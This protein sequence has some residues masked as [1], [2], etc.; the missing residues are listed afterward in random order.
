MKGSREFSPQTADDFPEPAFQVR[1][2]KYS[3]ESCDMLEIAFAPAASSQYRHS[4]RSVVNG[5]SF[6]EQLTQG[7][8]GLLRGTESE[9]LSVCQKNRV[10]GISRRLR[11]HLAALGDKLR[12]NRL[13][14]KHSMPSGGLFTSVR[15]PSWRAFRA[16]S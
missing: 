7:R 4:S 12:E 15:M 10:G 13:D 8:N 11:S 14:S 16:P 3:M 5:F 9:N 2:I 1:S 6:R